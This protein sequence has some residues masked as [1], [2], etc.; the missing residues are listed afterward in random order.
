MLKLQISDGPKDFF[1]KH[2]FD[3]I[4]GKVRNYYAEASQ[5]ANES[6]AKPLDNV[7]PCMATK[8]TANVLRK[9]FAEVSKFLLAAFIKFCGF[10]E[11]LTQSVIEP[12]GP[13]S[14]PRFCI[15]TLF[16]PGTKLNNYSAFLY[17][18]SGMDLF[19]YWLYLRTTSH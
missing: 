10:R 4:A 7:I 15:H 8:K 19:S 13:R 5:P 3:L 17:F 9:I 12:N 2:T 16:G 18:E 11:W 1:D 14:C 6:E